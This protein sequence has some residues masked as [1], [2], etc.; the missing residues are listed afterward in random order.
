[1]TVECVEQLYRKVQTVKFGEH[2]ASRV[3]EAVSEGLK[4]EVS[5]A[6]L[7]KSLVAR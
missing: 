6:L 2:F 3:E 7:R 5:R 1:M 4:V